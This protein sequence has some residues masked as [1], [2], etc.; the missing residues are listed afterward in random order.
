MNNPHHALIFIRL[1]LDFFREPLDQ[2]SSFFRGQCSQF[3]FRNSPA[4]DG[5]SESCRS[6]AQ[7][8]LWQR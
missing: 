3:G 8:A 6:C 2:L 7:G 4:R 5:T 1:F